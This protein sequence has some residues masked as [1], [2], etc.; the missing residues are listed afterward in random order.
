MNA[1][2]RLSAKGQVVIPKDVRDRY[3]LAPGQVLDV[4]E[5]PEGVLLKP[6]RKKDGITIEE[7]IARIRKVIKYDGPVVS[8]EEMNQS[9]EEM[10][11]AG[12]PRDW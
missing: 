8:I 9:I 7:A 1:Q 3:H 2:T 5:T 6:Q 11:S 12:G 10:W 4:V